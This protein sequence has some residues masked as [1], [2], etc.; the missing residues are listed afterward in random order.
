MIGPFLLA[1]VGLILFILL[2]LILSLSDLMVDKGVGI[3]L[4][5]RL[6]VFKL[7]ALLVLALPVASLFAAFLGLGRLVHDREIVALEAAGMSLKRILTPLLVLSLLIGVADFALYN[8]AAPLSEKAYQ[9]TLRDIIFQQGAP[10]LQE[11]TFFR[12]PEGRFFYVKRYEEDGMLEDVL[13][14]DVSGEVFP[15]AE[16]DVTIITANQGRWLEGAWKL[17]DGRVYGYNDQGEL[18]FTGTFAKLSVGVPQNIA[19]FVSS[20]RTPSE[21]GIS[22]LRKRI[23]TLRNSGLA[24]NNLIVECHAKI[25]IPL[26]AFV[27]V[28]LGGSFSLIFGWKS[29]AAGIVISLILVAMFQ[30]ILLWTQT[31]GRKGI[32]PPWLGAW[33][34]D[35]IF[36]LVGIYLFTNLDRLS[37]RDISTRL[38]RLIPFVSVFLIL[39]LMLTINFGAV[40]SEL[41]IKIDC[42]QLHISSDRNQLRAEGEVVLSY[43]DTTLAGDVLTMDKSDEGIWT[44]RCNGNVELDIGTKLTLT[45]EELTSTVAVENNKLVSKQATVSNFRGKSRFINSEGEEHTL[46]YR[47]ETA[48]VIFAEKTGEIRSIE[49]K[50]GW[51]TTCECCGGAM[52]RQPYSIKERK[53]FFYPDQLVVAFDLT[54]YAFGFPLL[55]LPAYVQPLEETLESPLFPAFGQ[56]NLRGWFLK[57]SV[58]F[59]VNQNNYGAVLLDYY[60]RFHEIGIGGIFHYELGKHRGNTGLYYFPARVGDQLLEVSFSHTFLESKKWKLNSTF[61]FQRVGE[62]QQLTFS[63]SSSSTVNGWTL[64]ATASR[65]ETED[66]TEDEITVERLPELQLSHGSVDVGFLSLTPGFGVGRYREWSSKE[67]ET[68]SIR[69]ASAMVIDTDP[70]EITSFTLKEKATL[71]SNYYSSPDKNTSRTSVRSVAGF[72]NSRLK[73]THTFQHVLG[74]SPFT[75]DTLTTTNHF[76]WTISGTGKTN[77]SL[78]GGYDLT[79]SMLDPVSLHLG[80]EQSFSVSLTASYNLYDAALTKTVIGGRYSLGRTSLSIEIPLYPSE[81]RVEPLSLE[82]DAKGDSSSISFSGTLDTNTMQLASGKLAATVENDK[83]WGMTIEENFQPYKKWWELSRFSVFRDFYDCLRLGIERNASEIWIFASIIAFPEAALRYESYSESIQI[84]N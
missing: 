81:H 73:F 27:F 14:Y 72:S 57:W 46:V 67:E 34:P 60:N 24:A 74:K 68:S 23:T 11:N 78:S 32:I 58:P 47:G 80:W 70:V 3:A 64:D 59:Y 20:S 10:Q 29:R 15:Q 62:D 4:L 82:L 41:P 53:M 2:N 12:G 43:G 52:D 30:G 56:N 28:L 6:L 71:T 31:L 36:G 66:E 84:G 54:A 18:T 8:W 13:I 63:F 76:A 40:S 26:A 44:L 9:D 16:A 45:G 37:H 21:M 77:L 1:L 83:G 51:L 5:L 33:S 61:A 38:R 65:S 55:W 69:V 22:E 48:L 19:R 49:M 75:F 50:D 39:T 7:P 79:K 17:Q 35:I 42:Q 25:A